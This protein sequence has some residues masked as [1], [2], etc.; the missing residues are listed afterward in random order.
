M[1][2]GLTISAIAHAAL[3]GW[4]LI[5]FT[6]QPLNTP[7]AESMPID[8]I[9]SDQLSKITAGSKTGK[10]ENPKPLVEKIAEKKPVDDT[11]AKV[12]EKK[13]NV[14]AA[15]QEK[16][17][18]EEKPVE[19]KP[20]P[21][22]PVEQP[23]KEPPKEEPKKAEKKPDPPKIDPIA[24]EIEKQQDKKPTPTPKPKVAEVKPPPPKP[25]QER[26]FDADK[27]S[28]LLDKRDIQRNAATGDTLN[29]MPSLGTSKGTAAQI[30]QSELDALRARLAQLW[31]PPAGNERPEELIVRIRVQFTPDGRI[32]GA[33]GLMTSAH[34]GS[35]RYQAAAAS[36]IRALFQG[37]PFTMLRRETYEQWKDM[38]ITFDPR[39]MFRS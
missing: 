38:E 12:T 2:K 10:K 5:A 32:Q 19:K 18:H 29:A 21:P 20:D 7:P 31:S 28:A 26:K 16:P 39:E 6:S 36:A 27:I 24:K 30:S 37:Q 13:E 1:R 8:I 3:L 33:P 25:K 35:P 11:E 22:K 4:G 14:T 9:S 15:S 23:K 34:S 17:Q